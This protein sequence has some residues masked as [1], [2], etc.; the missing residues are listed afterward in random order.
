MTKM[1][2]LLAEQGLIKVGKQIKADPRNLEDAQAF[3][4]ELRRAADIADERAMNVK[5]YQAR[6]LRQNASAAR[7]DADRIELTI[8]EAK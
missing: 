8:R 7:R 3:V 4:D 1:A 2:K 6:Q 5:L